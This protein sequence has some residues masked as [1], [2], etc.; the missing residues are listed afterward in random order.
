MALG[1]NATEQI[2]TGLDSKYTTR[3]IRVDDAFLISQNHPQK[4]NQN[5]TG[6]ITHYQIHLALGRLRQPYPLIN[7]EYSLDRTASTSAVEVS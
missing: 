7:R 5:V 4:D 2:Q 1:D 3:I 6:L